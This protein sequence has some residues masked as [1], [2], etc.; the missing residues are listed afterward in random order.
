MIDD[1]VPTVPLKEHL[2]ALREAD[3]R[4]SLGSLVGV[5]GVIAAIVAIV[6]R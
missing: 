3:L 6:T 4:S 2:E 5:V 1:T